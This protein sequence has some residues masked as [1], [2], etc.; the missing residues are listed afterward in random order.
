MNQTLQFVF[1]LKCFNELKHIFV[2][3]MKTFIPSSLKYIP[4]GFS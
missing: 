2:Y 3:Q 4:I 1:F